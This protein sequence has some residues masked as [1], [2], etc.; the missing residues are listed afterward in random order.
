MSMCTGRSQVNTDSI[1]GSVNVS[2]H[3]NRQHTF[4]GSLRV[5]Q[6]TEEQVRKLS[7]R[8]SRYFA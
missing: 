4:T 8:T 5:S 6:F 1:C 2:V 3:G 7:V